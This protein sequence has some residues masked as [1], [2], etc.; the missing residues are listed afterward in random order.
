MKTYHKTVCPLDCPDS[1]GLIATVEDGRVVA[2]S[3]DPEHPETRGSICRKTRRY[4]ERLTCAER[5]LHPLRRTGR[6]GLGEFEQISWDTALDLA[7]EKLGEIKTQFGGE[8]ILPWSYGGNM[9]KVQRF[10]GYPFFHRLGTLQL[11]MTICSATSDAGWAAHCGTWP[12]SAPE[13][14]AGSDLIVVWGINVP[15]TNMHFY[16]YIVAA[17]KRG[18]KLVVIDPYRNE[19][20]RRADLHLMIRPA[21]DSAFALAVAKLL[22][23]QGHEDAAFLAEHTTDFPAF[24]ARVEKMN[25]QELLS[26]CGL[27][28]EE[29]E[30]FTGLLVTRRKTFVRIGMGLTRNS[31]GG[32][33]VRAISALSALLGL[34]DGEAGRGVL[35]STESFSVDMEVLK[36][37]SLLARETPVV[38]MIQ[39]GEALTCRQ[40]PVKALFVYNANPALVAP[41]STTVRRGLE[42]ED[43][44]TIVHEQV[45]TSTA[46]Y[47]DLLLPATTFLENRDFYTAYGHHYLAVVEPAIEPMGEAWSNFDLFQKLARRMGF[48]DSAFSETV[49]G[50]IAACLKNTAGIPQGTDIDVLLAEGGRICSDRAERRPAPGETMFHFRA[51][52]A[53]DQPVF[54]C[55]IRGGEAADPDMAGRY[56]LLLITPPIMEML[57]STY[58]ERWQQ[59]KGEVLINPQDA[60]LYG[61]T[62]GQLVSLENYRGAVTRTARVS[63]DTLPGV[64][65]A[66]GLYWRAPG[67]EGINTVTSQKTSDL[68]GG[69]NF[70][71]SRVRVVAV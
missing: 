43:L 68:A 57:N 19:I 55:L 16:P 6:K 13:K 27:S 59:T 5:L 63:D 35:L 3:G 71:E 20:A 53:D 26:E 45:M 58:G 61:V 42:R 46:R 52:L 44:F 30:A 29:L 31:R 25:M 51:E 54:P 67:E 34:Y 28:R 39:L 40:P 2:V 37:K 9:G 48:A 1:C 65:V 64:A 7:A 49:D 22:L 60:A 36:R 4:P 18:A 17:R 41:D 23:E 38:N 11:D 66:G 24:A 12:G 8:A 33:A 10:A 47:A 15:V 62:D 32:M 56:P 14:A 21:G 69:S 70:H 50:R